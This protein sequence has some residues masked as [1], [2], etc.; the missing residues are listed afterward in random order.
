MV[1]RILT[2]PDPVLQRRACEVDGVSEE[3]K[4]LAEDM[5]ETMYENKGIGLAAPQVGEDIRLITVDTSGSENKSEFLVLINPVIEESL[6]GTEQEEACLSLP[7]FKCKVRRA[8]RITVRGR[9]L[10]GQERRMEAHGLL[11][12]C[13]QHEIDHLE[14]VVLLDRVSNLKRSLYEKKVRKWRQEQ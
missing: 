14:G 6:G 11:A 1:R 3:V 10:E 2:Y 13:L 9:D 12:V 8:D 4:R 5:K 7:G